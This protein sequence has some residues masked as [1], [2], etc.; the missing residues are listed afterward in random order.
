MK[1]SWLS[2]QYVAAVLANVGVPISQRTPTGEVSVSEDVLEGLR[3]KHPIIPLLLEY[4]STVRLI[5]MATTCREFIQQETNAIHAEWLQSGVPTGRFRCKNPN[6]QAIPPELRSA[7]V[8]RP[9]HYFLASDYDQIELRILAACAGEIVLLNAFKE[10][11]DPHKATAGLMLGVPLAQV[12]PEQRAIG[13]ICTYATLYGSGV[14]GLSH[15]LGVPQEKAQELLNRYFAAVPQLTRFLQKLRG[16]AEIQGYV[17]SKWGRRRPLSEIRSSNPKVQA[18]GLRSAVNGF[19]QSTSAD[20]IKRAMIQLAAVLPS[21]KAEMLL[22]LHDAALIEVPETVPVE[23]AA[24][25]VREAMEMGFEGLQLTVTI[26]AGPDWG[27]LSKAG[28]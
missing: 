6:L 1:A 15:R 13:K 7:F 16:D 22:T 8:A 27:H 3:D 21:L 26:S 25:V 11:H 20:I 24:A 2:S 12:T 14:R 23:T 28:P 19:A 4:R 10:G 5:G 17:Q 18:F 9:G